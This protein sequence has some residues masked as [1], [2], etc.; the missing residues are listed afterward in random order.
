MIADSRNLFEIHS[1]LAANMHR[2]TMGL[3]VVKANQESTA[4][5]SGF[6][7]IKAR[8]VSATEPETDPG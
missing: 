1:D 6:G 5:D 3:G 4:T 7:I 2:Y 8:Q